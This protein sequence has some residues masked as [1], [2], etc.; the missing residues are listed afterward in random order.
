MLG[1]VNIDII[2][3]RY[4]VRFVF[5]LGMIKNKNKIQIKYIYIIKDKIFLQLVKI[6]VND[7][8]N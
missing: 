4:K 2:V 3:E 6:F 7:K 5:L 8:K 1:V